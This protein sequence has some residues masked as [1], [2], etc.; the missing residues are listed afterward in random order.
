MRACDALPGFKVDRHS[1]TARVGGVVSDIASL[2]VASFS[3]RVS[4]MKTV[5]LGGVGFAEAAGWWHGGERSDGES[6]GNGRETVGHDDVLNVRESRGIDRNDV[7][8]RRTE[9]QWV[10]RF[11]VTSGYPHAR[12]VTYSLLPRRNHPRHPSMGFQLLASRLLNPHFGS[13]II[14]WAY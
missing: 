11:E 7:A 2:A 14:V 3:R 6:G 10:L 5:E 4:P 1:K 12:P 13:S 9:E 8:A